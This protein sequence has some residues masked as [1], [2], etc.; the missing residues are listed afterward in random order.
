MIRIAKLSKPIPMGSEEQQRYE[1]VPGILF[2][3]DKWMRKFIRKAEFY[4]YMV[5]CNDGSFY[6][7]STNNLEKRIKEHNSNSGRAAKYLQGKGPV[8]LVYAKEYAYYKNAL[9]AEIGIKKLTRRQKE[10]LIN[11]YD[12]SK[13]E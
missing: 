11:I 5:R 7:G 6:T 10:E 4:V 1:R 3:A 12:K 9:H 13:G 2:E 8:K